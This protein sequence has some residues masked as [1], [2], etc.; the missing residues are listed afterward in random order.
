VL[1][2]YRRL[3]WLL[4]VL[5]GLHNLEESFA[6][7]AFSRAHLPGL[8]SVTQ[9]QFNAAV[10]LITAAG[11]IITYLSIAKGL[12][13]AWAYAP[14]WL[15]S[16]LF[17]NALT[18]IAA[19]VYAGEAAPGIYTAVFVNIPFSLWLFRRA[20]AEKYATRKYF[21]YSCAAGLASYAPLTFA[22]LAAGKALCGPV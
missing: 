6:M 20:F 15:Q 2:T 1:I 9:P 11:F 10:I 12:R 13:G 17:V 5:F 19:S 8:H 21:I 14:L 3:L 18:H 16:I 7:V 22:S 4:P